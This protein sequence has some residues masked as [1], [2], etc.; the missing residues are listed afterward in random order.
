MKKVLVLG[1]TGRTG[2]LVIEELSK[3]ESV[4]IIAALRRQEDKER[5]P[6]LNPEIKT[7]IVDIDDVCSL[8][9]ALID[10]DI[11]I[12]A[13]RLREDISEDALIQLDQ[14][15]HQ[16]LNPSK[17]VHCITVGGAGSLRLSK[18]KRFWKDEHF[19]KQ[20]LPRGVAHAK[21]RDYL[22][23]STLKT[24]W[25]YL[26]PPP[27]YIAKGAKTGCYTR[28]HPAQIEEFFLSKSISYADFALAIVD[29]VMQ[30]WQGVHLIAGAN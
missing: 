20:T 11:I 10:S 25:A 24:T 28:Y 27:V 13:I 17:K 2:S 12:Q 16:A 23:A 7:A 3:Y 18:G 30:E 4:Q 22:E 5:L 21:L 6:K 14:R 26:I 19:P 9:K 29:A 1:A 8:R 15:I